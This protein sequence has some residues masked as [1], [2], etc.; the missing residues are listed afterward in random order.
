[1]YLNGALVSN[2]VL[3]TSAVATDTID[4]VTTDQSGLT[5]TS[6]RHVK[7]DAVRRGP[8]TGTLFHQPRFRTLVARLGAAM[9][10][11]SDE[12][13]H[14]AAKCVAIARTTS[15]PDTRT[16]LL[17]MAQK[18]HDMANGSATDFNAILREFNDQQMSKPVMQQ[19]QQIQPKKKE[20]E[21]PPDRD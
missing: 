9:P 4:Y 2:I 21:R 14:A 16:K 17:T 19:Q 20:D 5:S 15:D 6:T 13:R 3:D 10:D 8:F 1:M 12:Y 7:I 18:W 11:R